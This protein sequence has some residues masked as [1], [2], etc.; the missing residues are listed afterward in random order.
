MNF[1]AAA[2]GTRKD[3]APFGFRTERNREFLEMQ[4]GA[5]V[6]FLGNDELLVTFPSFGLVG[7]PPSTDVSSHPRTVRAVVFNTITGSVTATQD[8]LVEDGKPYIWSLGD[9]VLV[10]EADA[11]KLFGP[12]LTETSALPLDSGLAFLRTTPDAQHVLVGSMH[13]VHNKVDH[14][15][16]QK[17]D[18]RGSEEE[19]R[20]LLLDGAL[21]HAELIG[22]SSSFML[23]P[24]LLNSGLI[25]LRK[26]DNDHWHLVRRSWADR[27][28]EPMGSFRSS[29]RPEIASTAADLLAISTCDSASL[30]TQTF[31]LHEDGSPV[32][33]Q[34]SRWHDLPL[35][36]AGA[37]GTD[38]L[39]LLVTRGTDEYTRGKAFHLSL[40]KSQS[41]EVV[42]LRTGAPLASLAVPEPSPYTEAVALSPNASHLALL[43]GHSLLVYDLG[44]S[45]PATLAPTPALAPRP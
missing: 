43:S 18:I 35:A 26:E 15:L 45:S 39:A 11:L 19:V 33:D 34:A 20:W 10:H 36:F 25:E 22:T 5:S 8:W 16:L 17:S 30:D 24:V 32:R 44:S 29:C 3:L 27:Q 4:N 1:G 14:D 28:P 31:L 40:L 38:R 41:V 13:E 12:G 23:P 2:P 9:H 21:S 6:H 37:P 7:R 42:D